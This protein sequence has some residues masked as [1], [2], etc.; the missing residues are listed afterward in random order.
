M[1]AL[2]I[3]NPPIR[4]DRLCLVVTM[5]GPDDD[6]TFAMFNIELDEAVELMRMMDYIRTTKSEFPH[7]HHIVISTPVA[8]HFYE[9]IPLKKEVLNSIHAKTGY[10]VRFSLRRGDV[11][12]VKPGELD[13]EIVMTKELKRIAHVR[14]DSCDFC[15][16]DYANGVSV[17]VPISVLTKYFWGVS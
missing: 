11:Y 2:K 7:I 15:V 8:G 10:S 5:E 4:R 12:C 17:W 9:D 1:M 6:P 13:D 14:I 16:E 3:D